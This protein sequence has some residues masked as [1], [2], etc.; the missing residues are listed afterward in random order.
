MSNTI[1]LEVM[2]YRPGVDEK[3][4]PQVFDIEWTQ[5]MS[6]LDALAL[7][8]DDFE[9]EL[10]YRWSCRME[11]CGSCGMVVNGEPKLACSTFV[12]EYASA[13]KITV[14]ALDQFT[15]EKDLI[16]DADPFIEKLESVKPY[17]INK[18]PRALAD[19]EY[20]QTPAELAKFKQYTM[21]INCML[22]YQACPQVGLNA[23]FLGPAAT[24]LAHR[25]NLDN[26]DTGKVERFKVMNNENGIWPCT[27]VGY[28]SEVCPKHVD[29]AGAIQQAKAA[30]VPFWALS[31][32]KKEEA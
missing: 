29:P 22:C 2:R 15:I 18:N 6:I 13:G 17:I 16:V 12:R 21:C 28:C 32:L 11:V 19:K 5:D 23:D 14:G 7:V 25:Y 26:R 27:F 4:W 20:R 3:P 24:A 10:A 30:A 9:P 1:K 8:K 31:N